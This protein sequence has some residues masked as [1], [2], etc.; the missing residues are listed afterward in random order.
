MAAMVALPLPSTAQLFGGGGEILPDTI[1]GLEDLKAQCVSSEQRALFE[2]A[3]SLKRL[4]WYRHEYYSEIDEHSMKILSYGIIQR[5]TGRAKIAGYRDIRDMS[6]EA[7]TKSDP[8][9]FSRPN[10]RNIYWHSKP[11]PQYTDNDC[12]AQAKKW[13]NMLQAMERQIPHTFPEISRYL[14]MVDANEMIRISKRIGSCAKYEPGKHWAFFNETSFDAWISNNFSGS[15]GRK[16]VLSRPIYKQLERELA[17][18][19]A[20]ADAATKITFESLGKADCSTLES[21]IA[22]YRAKVPAL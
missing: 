6:V 11:K 15:Y 5:D 13:T 10:F 21:A 12:K 3:K 8:Y 17:A 19:G 20:A 16:E 22:T 4:E 18:L 14:E 7:D 1:L 9:A 2:Y